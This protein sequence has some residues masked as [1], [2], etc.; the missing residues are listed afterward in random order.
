MR[1][2]RQKENLVEINMAS[3]VLRK[4][5]VANSKLVPL[6][7]WRSAFRMD[8]NYKY[9]NIYKATMKKENVYVTLDYQTMLYPTEQLGKIGVFYI[10]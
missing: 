9:Y 4:Q 6:K 1:W 2:R 3:K 8:N 5:N 7:I 10:F